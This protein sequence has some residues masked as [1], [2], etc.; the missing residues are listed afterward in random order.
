MQITAILN[1]ILISTPIFPA[2]ICCNVIVFGSVLFSLIQ[3]MEVHPSLGVQ[4]A[5]WLW[6]PFVMLVCASVVILHSLLLKRLWHQL[7]SE[8]NKTVVE[9]SSQ[10]P[11]PSTK[12]LQLKGSMSIE[13]NRTSHHTFSLTLARGHKPS[14]HLVASVQQ[15]PATIESHWLM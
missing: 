13:K 2:N 9:S 5:L 11:E 8:W 1:A 15:V 6:M 12:I 4:C 3:I 7:C 10:N 14:W